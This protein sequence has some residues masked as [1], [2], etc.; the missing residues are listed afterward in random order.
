MPVI[1]C[2]TCLSSA[3]VSC[4]QWNRKRRQEVR[5][6]LDRRTKIRGKNHKEDEC[7]R[8]RD[9]GMSDGD[10]KKGDSLSLS[11]FIILVSSLQSILAHVICL[12]VCLQSRNEKQSGGR[13]KSH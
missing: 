9:A 7:E 13:K 11:S 6:E 5:S 12:S 10:A 3:Y 1:N 2:S 4:E 8:T